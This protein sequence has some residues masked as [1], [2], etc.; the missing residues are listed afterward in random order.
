[1]SE[2]KEALFRRIQ[3][4][5][6]IAGDERADPNEAAA[7][8]SMAEKVM[9][10]YQIEHADLILNDL[11]R[12]D[13]LETLD[14]VASAKTNG[15]QVKVVPPWAGWIAVAVSRLNECS[16]TLGVNQQGEACVRFYGFSED[17]KLAGWTFDYL[18][19]TTNRLVNE[20]KKN[21]EYVDGG[22][23]VLNS[24]R[25]GVAMG[26]VNALKK[27]TQEKQREM[28][29][30][31]TG[32]ALMVV[33]A[34]AIAAK[35]GAFRTRKSSSTVDRTTSAFSSG[36]RDGRAVDVGRRA[37]GGNSSSVLRLA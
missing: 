8:A 1:M 26:I 3:K 27:L 16:A 10:K 19:N 7:A 9:R 12:G 21:P 17:I 29:E 11:R 6:A 13:N 37:V 2:N 23:K 4:L 15:T 32:N 20:F 5:L 33:K 31:A 36:V 14:V 24:Y 35:Y 34:D 28:A 18:V 22:R 25:Q 30:T